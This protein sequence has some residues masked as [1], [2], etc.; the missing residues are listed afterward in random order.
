MYLPDPERFVSVDL[1][2][3]RIQQ[4][5]QTIREEVDRMEEY[6]RVHQSRRSRPGVV[7][8][9]KVGEVVLVA[10]APS[11]IS[12]KLQWRWRGPYTI[13]GVV[14][15]HS[16]MVE[17]FIGPK[18]EPERVHA[19]R[20]LR[21][22][23]VSTP[24]TARMLHLASKLSDGFIVDRIVAHRVRD[25]EHQFEV[26]WQPVGDH[27]DVTWEPALRLYEDVPGLVKSFVRSSSSLT[28]AVRITL[29][30]VLG[31]SL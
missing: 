2:D 27:V 25:E 11:Q 15:T 10:R 19:R 30:D 28:D 12:S 4:H 9:F 8:T 21:V 17:R 5:V 22:S 3:P 31:F 24:P 18:D 16:Y 7:S 23:G 1:D 26:H 13:V 6:I 14:D 20:L 29:A